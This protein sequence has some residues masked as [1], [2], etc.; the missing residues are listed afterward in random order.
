MKSIQ[1]VFKHLF[2]SL[3]PNQYEKIS[4]KLF[5]HSVNLYFKV[6]LLGLIIMTILFIPKVATVSNNIEEDL[7][8]FSRAE[9][10]V[11]FETNEAVK[12]LSYPEIQVDSNASSREGAFLTLGNESM[13]YRNHLLWGDANSTFPNSVDMKEN[14][15]MVSK[16]VNT[17]AI[18]LLPGIIIGI[19]LMLFFVSV[20]IILLSSLIT[21]PIIKGKKKLSF[22]DVAVISM[23]SILV[24][25]VL[26]FVLIPLSKL[27]WLSIILYLLIYLLSMALVKGHRL[28]SSSYEEDT[29]KTKSGKKEK[30]S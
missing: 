3:N 14:R 26:A 13:Y 22:R 9:V 18:V 4:Q 19:S 12:L 17:I 28:H 30:K 20:A 5:S 24:P 1:D 25:L 29:E 10:S 7:D 15:E 8:T 23:H 27:Y 16:L 2:K 21:Y 6:L 11:D